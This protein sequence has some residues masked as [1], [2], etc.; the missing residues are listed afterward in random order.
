MHKSP[1]KS[2]LKNLLESTTT[3]VRAQWYEII[4]VQKRN[5]LINSFT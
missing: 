4:R 3:A 2:R 5:L 1:D